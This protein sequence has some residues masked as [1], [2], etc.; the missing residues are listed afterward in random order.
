MA[1]EH[2]LKLDRWH[3]PADMP[4]QFAAAVV[5]WETIVRIADDDFRSGDGQNRVSGRWEEGSTDRPLPEREPW[6]LATLRDGVWH[7]AETAAANPPAVAREIRRAQAERL[8]ATRRWTRG[9][10]DLLQ[11]L[12]A[13]E[14]VPREALLAGD[15]GRARSLKSL[16][17][18]TLADEAA[19]EAPGQPDTV[20]ALL[21]DGAGPVVWCGADT[22]DLGAEILAWHEKRQAKATARTGRHAAEREKGEEL[23]STI[24]AAVRGVFPGIPA[25][26]AAGAATRLAPSVGK[27]GR[28]PGLQAMVDAVVE[29]R[30]ERWR[31][32][33]ASE[34]DVAARLEAMQARG[35][36]NRARKRYRDQRAKDRVEEEIRNWRG[37]LGPVTSHR[38]G[39]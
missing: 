2:I 1:A 19:T 25:E 23:K 18:L 12:Q 37:G 32:A 36:N 15:E 7:L 22:R 33:V 20:R 30:L 6:A 35:D 38:L 21:K 24:A 8:T 34:P 10:L 9:D 29:I 11:A 13:V 4:E 31:Q 27:L 14:A 3:R 5:G 28:R 16:L 39:S 17:V 26:V